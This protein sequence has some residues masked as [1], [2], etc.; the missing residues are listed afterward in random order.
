MALSIKLFILMNLFIFCIHLTA[1]YV[2]LL[3]IDSFESNKTNSMERNV[4]LAQGTTKPVSVF[5]QR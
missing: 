2:I 3:F 1:V 5:A 4:S